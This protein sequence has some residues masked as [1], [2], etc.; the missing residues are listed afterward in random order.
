MKMQ[1]THQKAKGPAET[2]A[3]LICNPTYT[4]YNQRM[5]KKIT[6]DT[7]ADQIAKMDARI[8]RGFASADTKVKAIAEDIAKIATKDDVAAVHTQ[9][10]SIERQLRET[11]TEIRLGDLEQKVFGASRA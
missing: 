8:E 11:K 6:L 3:A 7:L 2:H 1:R 4:E 5:A 10:S 9:V